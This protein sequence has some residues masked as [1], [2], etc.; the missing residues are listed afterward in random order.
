MLP[1]TTTPSLTPLY[2][3]S[4][5]VDTG[6]ASPYCP[7]PHHR[8]GQPHKRGAQPHKR[9]AQPHKRGAQPHNTNARK[10]GAYSSRNPNLLQVALTLAIHQAKTAHTDQ[11]SVQESTFT[12][13]DLI[14]RLDQMS[15]DCTDSR[16]Q[17]FYIRLLIK[18]IEA[19]SKLVMLDY[20]L[21]AGPRRLLTLSN[22]ASFL[23]SNYQARERSYATT[24]VLPDR[25]ANPGVNTL[26]D[27]ACAPGQKSKPKSST[28]NLPSLKFP[29]PLGEGLGVRSTGV[30][31][32]LTF[33]DPAPRPELSWGYSNNI[34][35]PK[36]GEFG[37]GREGAFLNDRHWQFLQPMFDSLHQELNAELKR[38]SRLVP[39]YDRFLLDGILWKLATHAKWSELPSPYPIR[40]CQQLYR[41]LYHTGRMSLILSA[42]Y[43]DL[44]VY[45]DSDLHP[46][47]ASGKYI[48]YRN[49]VLFKTNTPPTWQELIALLLLQC[50]QKTLLRQDRNRLSRFY[51]SSLPGYI[52]GL[53]RMPSLRIS[54]L[55][56]PHR[57][58]PFVPP[59][60]S[61]TDTL[62]GWHYLQIPIPVNHPLI[63][64]LNFMQNTPLGHIN[65]P[66]N[67]SSPKSVVFG[68][69]GRRP[70]GVE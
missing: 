13:D 10:H 2:G 8:G 47:A 37:G 20:K 23:I 58:R 56:L 1:L 48:L 52:P 62:S 17:L 66:Q 50:N 32:P 19:K 44:V 55:G 24:N 43:E 57:P 49:R 9:G 33:T 6:T 12:L 4:S 63:K 3:P 42:L 21:T 18:A 26:V 59:P 5:T 61:K 60:L 25:I 30:L 45:G 69:G 34:S 54:F 36:F 27:R 40:R 38:K 67:H 11:G 14:N 35:S 53:L 64:Y 7:A 51:L 70:E 22:Q 31:T 68:G 46:F 16:A 39:F 41:L 65:P 29:S 15:N 28:I